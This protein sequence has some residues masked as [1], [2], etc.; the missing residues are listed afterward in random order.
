MG[1]ES[2]NDPI[3]GLSIGNTHWRAVI[4]RNGNVEWIR[5]GEGQIEH[6]SF[7]NINKII[8]KNY[9]SIQFKDPYLLES[10][11]IFERNGKVYCKFDVDGVVKEMTPEDIYSNILLD[12]KQATLEYLNENI[13]RIYISVPVYFGPDQRNVIRNAASEQGLKIERFLLDPVNTA[14]FNTKEYE[15][16]N[17]ANILV[18][19]MGRKSLDATVLSR[20]NSVFEVYQAESNGQLGSEKFHMKLRDLFVSKFK[21]QHESLRDVNLL[22]N[23]QVNDLL[24]SH[25]EIAMIALSNDCKYHI[26][27]PSLYEGKDFTYTLTRDYFEKHCKDLLDEISKLIYSIITETVF[28]FETVDSVILSGDSTNNP[29]I[30]KSI[31]N[32][33]PFSKVVHGQNPEVGAAI[34]AYMRNHPESSVPT[35][36]LAPF[37]IGIEN[38]DHQLVKII[39]RGDLLPTVKRVIF[40][41]LDDFS[42]SAHLKIFIGESVVNIGP[43]NV[44]IGDLI[45]KGIELTE[46]GNAQIQISFQIDGEYNLT[47]TALDL[48][49]NAKSETVISLHSFANNLELIDELL[50]DGIQEVTDNVKTE[51]LISSFIVDPIKNHDEF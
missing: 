49:T 32:R 22:E 5:D 44:H 10:N 8:G 26:V 15:S 4:I 23:Q 47:V 17:S 30:R 50:E 33:F 36:F 40:S 37:S 20:N 1:K 13:T 39:Q 43:R 27:I 42:E 6:K 41:N 25:A 46:S 14:T 48:K 21:K 51:K 38:S 11:K 16:N 28:Y 7:E 12:V 3:I 9:K 2:N 19:D 45:L 18:V 34:Q 31:T 35:L 29:L 24:M